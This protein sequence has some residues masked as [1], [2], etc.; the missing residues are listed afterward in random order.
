[1]GAEGVSHGCGARHE[2]RDAHG[3]RRVWCDLVRGEVQG[4][5]AGRC[6]GARPEARDR[7]RRK[8][9]PCD[10]ARREFFEESASR[11]V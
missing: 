5:E 4:R 8:A 11:E 1:M 7:T 3:A 10:R 9:D 6:R 2:A